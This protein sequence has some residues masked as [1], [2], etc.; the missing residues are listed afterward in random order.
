MWYVGSGLPGSLAASAG[1]EEL[2]EHGP[3]GGQGLGQFCKHL[4]LRV[5]YLTLSLR[6]LGQV[7]EQVSQWGLVHFLCPR[8]TL[9]STVMGNE[10]GETSFFCPFIGSSFIQ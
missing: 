8:P 3:I 5:V 7:P 4:V 1:G 10:H 6:H 2:P 9:G